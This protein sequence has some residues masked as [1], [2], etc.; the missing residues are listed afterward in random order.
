LTETEGKRSSYHLLV[1][2][3]EGGADRRRELFD[4]FQTHNIRAQ[5]HYIPVHFQPWHQENFGFREGDFPNAERYYE[6]CISLPLFPA[7][8]DQDVERVASVLKQFLRQ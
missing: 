7:M 2:L 8:V 1:A 4:Y 5:V 3:I 6:G